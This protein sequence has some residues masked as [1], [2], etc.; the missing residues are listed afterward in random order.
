MIA[1]DPENEPKGAESKRNYF[2]DELAKLGIENERICDESFTER[3]F[4]KL[5]ATPEF[6]FRYAEIMAISMPLCDHDNN[7]LHNE[8][9]ATRDDSSEK[10]RTRKTYRYL[11]KESFQIDTYII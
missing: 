9:N 2:L 11:T 10:K 4:I 5:H 1:Y 8:L 7:T 6:L 3:K